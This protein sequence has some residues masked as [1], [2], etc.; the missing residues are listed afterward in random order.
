[1]HLQRQ[2]GN[3]PQNGKNFL[4]A[5]RSIGALLWVFS[6]PN[7]PKMASFAD[8]GY[9][10]GRQNYALHLMLFGKHCGQIY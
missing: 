7:M 10:G 5:L 3:I 1:M 4:P 2:F 6:R 9:E 8:Y